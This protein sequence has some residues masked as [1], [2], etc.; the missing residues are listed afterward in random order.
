MTLEEAWNDLH[1]AVPPGWYCGTPQFN[2]R[3]NEWSIYAFDTTEQVK[4]GKRSREWT[5]VHPTQDG[6]LR[7]MA[8]CLRE[9][10]EGR[11]PR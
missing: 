10:A 1:D 2:Q 11:V 6:V 8:R 5:T 7:E 9:I 4:I 3:R